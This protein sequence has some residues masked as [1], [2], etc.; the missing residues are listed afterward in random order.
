MAGSKTFLKIRIDDNLNLCRQRGREH[1]PGSICEPMSA[2]A[3]IVE[4]VAVCATM[5]YLRRS[6]SPP[7]PTSLR[8]SKHQQGWTLARNPLKSLISRM[9]RRF[10]QAKYQRLSSALNHPFQRTRD[11]ADG[12]RPSRAC[13]LPDHSR[14]TLH[15]CTTTAAGEPLRLRDVGRIV[16]PK[17]AQN[18]SRLD[19]LTIVAKTS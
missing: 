7:S 9:H 3:S 1:A 15:A 19:A 8:A 16:M 5:K 18:Y 14:D 17:G 10:L 13:N 6:I 4:G 2:F 12:P 11:S